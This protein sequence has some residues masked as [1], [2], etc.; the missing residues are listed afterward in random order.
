DGRLDV[1]VG[2]V[3]G[4]DPQV[5]PRAWDQGS[6]SI[7]LGAPGGF[8]TRPDAIVYG[9]VPDAKGAWHGQ[10][11]LQMA[12]SLTAGDVDGDGKCD[13]IPGALNSHP[14]STAA[15]PDP[16]RTNDGALWVFAGVGQNGSAPGGVRA[17]P[18]RFYA[19]GDADINTQL[20]RSLAAGDLDGDGKAE[21]IA[22]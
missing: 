13:L 11:S 21:I 20:S 4:E 8:P 1:A 19:G 3:L 7:F 16:S 9:Q 2:S 12:W 15:N 5:D 10:V 18:S 22:G 17:T 14:P 6:V